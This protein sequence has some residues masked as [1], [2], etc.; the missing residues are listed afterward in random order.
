MK[1]P[2][3][4]NEETCNVADE[5]KMN[6]RHGRIHRFKEKSIQNRVSYDCVNLVKARFFAVSRAAR[7]FCSIGGTISLGFSTSKEQ[8]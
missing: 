1:L 2:I 7:C 8:R 6:G 5:G 4:K 3:L